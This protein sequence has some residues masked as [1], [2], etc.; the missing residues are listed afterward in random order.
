[1]YITLLLNMSPMETVV[2][3]I[4]QID[5]YAFKIGYY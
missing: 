3:L 5:A 4:E 1:M 2:F